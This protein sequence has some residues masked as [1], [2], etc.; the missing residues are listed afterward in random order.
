M[1]GR[2]V[3]AVL[4]GASTVV[5]REVVSSRVDTEGV[6]R[7]KPAKMLMLRAVPMMSERI[8]AL[9][10]WGDAGGGF[11]DLEEEGGTDGRVT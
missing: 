3:M 9:S 1:R 2:A 4:S 8:T 7:V 5:L 6:S 11:V 10:G